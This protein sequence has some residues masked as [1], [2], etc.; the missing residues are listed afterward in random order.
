MKRLPLIVLFLGIAYIAYS[1]KIPQNTS[2]F[3]FNTWGRLPVLNGG[4]LKP[5]DTVA[6]TSLLLLS[7]KQ[8]VRY[9]GKT[10]GATEW[11][12]YTLF[13]PQ[14]SQAFP[15]FEIDDPD[16][17]GSI[18]IQQTT[19]RRFSYTQIEPKLAD[20]ERLANQAEP[21]K[22]EQRSRF[23]TAVTHLHN[24]IALYHKLQLS[25]QFPF[26]KTAVISLSDFE[27]Q[28]TPHALQKLKDPRLLAQVPTPLMQAFRQLRFLDSA[29]L[30]Y[31]FPVEKAAD[32]SP[33]WVSLGRAMVYRLYAQAYHPGLVAYAAMSDAWRTKDASLFNQYALE[34]TRWLS[35]SNTTTLQRTRFEFIFNSFAPFYRS[36]VL[37]L[38]VFM[39]VL[40]F[41]LTGKKEFNQAAFYLL[42]LAFTVHTGGLIARMVLQGRPPVTNLYSSAIFVGWVAVF[43]GIILER[44]YKRGIG[45][46]T[47]S[48]I[49][50]L[51]LIIAHHLAASG[52]TLEMMRAVLDS[53]FWLATHV[54]SITIGYGS[55]FLSGFMATV[56]ILRNRFDRGWNSELASTFERM[57]YGIVCFSCLL[58]FIGTILGGIWAD[59][60]WGRF[61][62]WDPKENGA[63]LIV[64]WNV[65]I[66]HARWGGYAKGSNLMRFAL[67]GNMITAL[68]WFG[69]NMLGIGLHS[70]G[71]MDKAFIWL[72]L[73]IVTQFLLL[74]ISYSTRLKNHSPVQD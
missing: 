63:L 31:P 55:T 24:R 17:L 8:A 5:L 47:A 58:S 52:D 2:A 40:T 10:Y 41:W 54:V 29:A 21:V 59:Q 14:A 57:V 9:E 51:T 11:L 42:V 73:F 12:I 50:F 38:V 68:S 33:E 35:Q 15:V 46:L 26:A 6:R 45:S 72:L 36:L 4:R 34:Y 25:M 71:F 66:L 27:V 1:F 60:S 7:G 62:G 19:Q 67:L 13:E 32:A 20:I 43:L 3:D 28:L 16:V 49:G 18:G 69:V 61:W 56:Y 64:L 22:P 74:S 48:L 70:Y 37:Y 65:F 30:F 23:Q 44:L 53:N 39:L